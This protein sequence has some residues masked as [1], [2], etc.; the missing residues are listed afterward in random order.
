MWN[1]NG[2][3]DGLLKP[4]IGLGLLLFGRCVPLG[5]SYAADPFT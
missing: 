5:G 1:D 4:V 3:D 2:V